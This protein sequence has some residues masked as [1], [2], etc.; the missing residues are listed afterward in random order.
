MTAILNAWKLDRSFV[1]GE[2]ESCQV[3]GI[4]RLGIECGR[5]G[6]AVEVVA[7]RDPNT[8]Y[9]VWSLSTEGEGWIQWRKVNRNRM[10]FVG[11]SRPR[12]N[13]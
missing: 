8:E 13:W 3:V 4:R 5:L 6:M 11:K 7:S 10:A 2:G 1:L 12:L 9:E